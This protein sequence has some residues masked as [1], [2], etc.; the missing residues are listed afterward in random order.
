M[1]AIVILALAMGYGYLNGV[2]G[3]ANVVATIISSRALGPRQALALAAIGMSTGPF[4]LG[5]AVASTIGSQLVSPQAASADVVIA[6]MMGAIFWSAITLWLKIPSSISQALVGGLLGAAWAGFGS[7]AILLPGLQKTLIALF[8]SP[9]LGL[10]VG[11]LAVRLSYIVFASATPHINKWFNRVQIFVSLVVAMAFAANDAQKIMGVMTLGMVT[12]GVLKS[13]AVPLWI[14]G[15]SALAI[16][17]GALVGGQRLIHTL[18]G[19][20]YKIR[21]VHGFSAQLSSGAVILAAGLLGGPV[22]GS[23]VVTS[24]ILGAG[25]ADRLQMIRWGIA[26]QIVISWVLTLP[27]SAVVGALFYLVL[28]KVRLL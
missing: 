25:S 1:T 14:V 23:Q 19:K 17:V 28:E 11:F 3:S 7:Q 6:G 5:V 22:S 26:R 12:T 4:L 18:S 2:H 15:L 24:A 13:F 16:G 21:P 9:I 10:L 27:I 8:L 20:F